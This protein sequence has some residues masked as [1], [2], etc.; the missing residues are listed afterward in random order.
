[1]Y[2][3]VNANVSLNMPTRTL[4]VCDREDFICKLLLCAA[5]QIYKEIT[6]S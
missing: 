2:V 5:F 6:Y 4:C 3:C 1:M